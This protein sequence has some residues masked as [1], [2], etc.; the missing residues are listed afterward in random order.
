MKKV[1]YPQI[2]Q[3]FHSVLDNP[4]EKYSPYGVTAAWLSK[5][6]GVAGKIISD[7]R[8]EKSAVSTET[9]WRLIEAM[10]ISPRLNMLSSLATEKISV[11]II[12]RE[13]TPEELAET[14]DSEIDSVVAAVEYLSPVSRALIMNAL[15]QC[16]RIEADAEK[17]MVLSG[18]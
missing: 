8:L 3:A 2:N 14:I 6:S 11:D 18:N 5:E 1:K 12:V 13:T 15:A 4:S 9:L 7:F 16:L 17:K 10:P